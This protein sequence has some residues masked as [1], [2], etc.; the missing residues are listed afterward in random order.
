[1]SADAF[2][3]RM[4]VL[5]GNPDSADDDAFIDEYREML[6]G[7]DTAVLKAAGDIIRST[8]VRRGWPTPGEVADAVR[9]AAWQ[10]SSTRK[11]A[12]PAPP[13][14]EY[15]NVGPEDERY[16]AAL[17]QARTDMPAYARLIEARGF[18]KVKR[19]PSGPRK[20]AAQ[21]VITDLSKRMTGERE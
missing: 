2:I 19:L 13:P 3:N 10:V 9:K 18:I 11:R 21:G 16:I 4:L 6:K 15:E 7:A 20:V 17:T 12:E 14:D 8:H 1:M 5:Y